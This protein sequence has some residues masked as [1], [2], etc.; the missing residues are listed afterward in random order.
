MYYLLID[1]DECN[2]NNHKC[3]NPIETCEDTDGSYDCGC[4]AG[5]TKET[6]RCVGLIYYSRYYLYFMALNVIK[7]PLPY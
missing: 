2:S 4:G 7:R 6:D 3:Q 5:Y 1:I